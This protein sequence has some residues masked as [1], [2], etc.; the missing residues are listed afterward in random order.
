[1][2]S[3]DA[4]PALAVAFHEWSYIMKT[5]SCF[6]KGCALLLAASAVTGASKPA[7][8]DAVDANIFSNTDFVQ[9]SNSAPASPVSYFFD[10]GANFQT[11]GD[12]STATATYPGGSQTLS[13]I[14]PT[15]FTFG[16]PFFT[17]LGAMQAAF[18]FGTYTVTA[19]GNQPTSTS[20]LNYSIMN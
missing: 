11:A 20:S 5:V 10:I 12:Y 17:T 16:S 14:G 8:A 3:L 7:L 18:P 13:L 19:N 1:M 4:V 9:T 15:T 6:Q 2:I